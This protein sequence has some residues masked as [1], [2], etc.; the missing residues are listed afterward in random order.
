MGGL[1]RYTRQ[2]YSK[3]LAEA[4][5]DI[6]QNIDVSGGL[7]DAELPNPQAPPPYQKISC[8]VASG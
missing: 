6:G 4:S 8:P 3:G 1:V 5:S 2:V 7:L